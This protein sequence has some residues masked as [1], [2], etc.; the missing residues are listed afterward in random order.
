M[1][2]VYKFEY[3]DMKFSKDG[4]LDEL[5]ALDR[6]AI[7]SFDNYNVGDTVVAIINKTMGNKKI[8]EITK[9]VGDNEFEILTRDNEK[10]VVEKQLLQKPLELEPQELWS[11]WAKGGASVER[12]GDRLWFENSL[13]KLF[14]GYKYSL[15]GRIQL[16][17]GQEFVTGNKAQLTAFNCFVVKSPKYHEYGLSQFLDVLDVAK[18]EASIMRRGGGVGLNISRINKVSGSGASK[19]NFVFYLDKEHKDYEELLDRIKLSKFDDVNIVDNKDDFNNLIEKAHSQE[20]IHIMH[21]IDSVDGLF[22]NLNT[23]VKESYRGKTVM[24]DFNGLRER[25]AIVKGVNGR[26]SGAVSWMELFVLVASLLQQKQIDNVEFSE[27]FSHIVHLIIQGGSRRGALML[28]C[29]TWN[30]NVLKFI[31]RKETSGYLTGANISVGVS[32][33]FMDLVFKGRNGETSNEISE[34]LNIWDVMIK[35]AW[36][37]AEPGVIWLERYNKESNSW[38]FNEIIATNPCGEQ[39][40]PAFG[41]CNL[42]HFVL[43][44]FYDEKTKDVNWKDLEE[45]IF[46]AVRLQDNIIDYTPYFLEENKDV[47]LNERRIGIGSM[48]LGTLLI[49]MKL[50]YGSPEGN[51]F[52]DKLYKFI[53]YNAYK[54]SILLAREKGAFPKFEYESYIKS[55]FMQ[56]LLKEFPDLDDILK[57]YGIRNVTL[58]TQAPTGSTGTYIDN[59]PEFRNKFGGTTTGIEPYFSWKYWRAGRLGMAEQTVELAMKYMEENNIKD[60]DELP[61]YFVT[62]MDLEPLDHIK[63]QA[64]IQKWTDSSIS[65]TA[66]CPS[67]FTVEQTAELY[68]QSYLLGL[69]G[70]TIYR[71]GSRDAQVLAT[72]KE[73][74]K[75][76]VHIEAEK[77]EKLKKEEQNTKNIDNNTN[78]NIINVES[79]IH[80]VPSRLFG[81]R[82]KV[83]YQSGDRMS[84]AYV[85]VYVDENGAPIEVW[86]EPTNATDKDM[87]DAL[88]RMT[89]QFLRFGATKDNVDQ[90]VKH[91]KA[92]KMIM[93]LPAIVGR[94]INDIYYGKI[95][96]PTKNNNKDNKG[97]KLELQECPVCGEKAY[98]KGNCICHACGQSKCN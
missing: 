56:R 45:S 97:K 23:M 98:D 85:H 75:L 79:P 36:K 54:A 70:M 25:N 34:A 17:L 13:R 83:K 18:Y 60:I 10:Y 6:Y 77:L 64:T 15:G 78:I 24:I 74:A 4:Q 30:E 90:A 86:I 29:E 82:E 49:K 62:S 44:R 33:K 22:S 48:G 55:E 39:G 67:D 20:E 47:Q 3:D 72:N 80:K 96:L 31:K 42:G 1:D 32:D 94:I 37:S 58:L 43:P 69:K 89:T 9:K 21:G 93:S 71:D 19:D 28:V 68:E 65:K 38:Y 27:I 16:M 11:R 46:T 73:D 81:M 50:K 53:A 84:K 52:V 7:P 2:R 66:N 5:I 14:D 63:V 35:S 59:I 41:V 12:E 91:L 57:K 76:E 61:Q 88:G 8:G 51:K 26:S 92:G 87:A 40:L 95:E